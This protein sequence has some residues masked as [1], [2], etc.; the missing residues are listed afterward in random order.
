MEEEA[1]KN[2]KGDIMKYIT[3]NTTNIHQ[4]LTCH[5]ITGT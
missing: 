1:L 2:Y 3:Y 4:K 5:M